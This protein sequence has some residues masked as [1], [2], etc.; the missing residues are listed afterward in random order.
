MDTIRAAVVG[1]GGMGSL[2][3]QNAQHIPQLKVVAFVDRNEQRAGKLYTD[4][5][6]EYWT[7]DLDRVL[8]DPT[9]QAV[10][11]ATGWHR[12]AHVNIA[13]AAAQ[14]GKHLFIE[15][16]LAANPAECDEI[17]QAIRANGVT[18]MAN[19]CFRYAPLVEKARE[20]VG[21]PR[22]TIVQCVDEP[23]SSLI[24]NGCH[25]VDL[26]CWLNGGR[27]ATV[28][29]A[30]ARLT[31][32]PESSQ[33]GIDQLICSVTF[34]DGGIASIILGGLGVNP[35]T[36]KFSMQVFGDGVGASLVDRF[37][38]LKLWGCELEEIRYRIDTVSRGR[39]GYMGHFEALQA[40]AR[41]VND[42]VPSPIPV[43]QARLAIDVIFAG[44]ESARTGTV[45][46]MT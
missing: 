20:I 8:N 10:L 5:Q 1:C 28:A 12:R 38:E 46:R 16:P 34:P 21:T 35:H 42:G 3:T 26:A 18:L 17:V 39:H 22:L 45:V 15:K 19:Y 43:E 14:A 29:A 2:H 24:D 30:G 25:L 9:I 33:H 32:S 27:P 11:I 44:F 37:R 13:V 40:F 4:A 7:T 31:S 36:S 41:C 23:D 6:G